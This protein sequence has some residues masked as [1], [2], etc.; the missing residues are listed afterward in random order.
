MNE[1]SSRFREANR[2]FLG[3]NANPQTQSAGLPESAGK[4][5]NRHEPRS[6]APPLQIL[7]AS[8]TGTYLPTYDGNGNV[9][10]YLST[11]GAIVAHY[12]Y[13]P[14]GEQTAATGTQA[15][16][17][18]H[19]FSTKPLDAESGYYYYGYRSYDPLSGRWVNRDPIGERGGANLFGMVGNNSNNTVDFLGLDVA[20]WELIETKTEQG[21]KSSKETF[22]KT[23][24]T[25]SWIK[26]CCFAFDY[27]VYNVSSSVETREVK[28]Y[29]RR[30]DGDF[31][32][33]FNDAAANW[34]IA[35][36]VAGVGA[37]AGSRCKGP[38]GQATA[39]AGGMVAAECAVI[40]GI[41]W[42]ANSVMNTAIPNY[43]YKTE[44]GG[45]YGS[46]G[47][48]FS[49]EHRPKNGGKGTKVD[50]SYCGGVYGIQ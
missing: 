3:M 31:A 13:G 35:G 40:S 8:S 44:N 50:D 4:F 48:G 24:T 28:K 43:E 9:S 39:A 37:F 38:I 42:K 32:N 6:Q 21:N 27:D 14:F 46:Q 12:E 10:E 1:I 19:R 25:Y 7:T 23:V 30:T 36:G 11:T 2:L 45:W 16:D 22:V 20:Q 34:A 26:K 29:R 17:F 33:L 18:R 47:A 15:A 5:T 41:Y 49:Q